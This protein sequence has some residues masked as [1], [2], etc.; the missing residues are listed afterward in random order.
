MFGG[1]HLEARVSG[2]KKTFDVRGVHGVGPVITKLRSI[3][4][5]GPGEAGYTCVSWYAV[6][7]RLC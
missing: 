6:F 5:V 2:E 7:D 3:S 4:T 1:T